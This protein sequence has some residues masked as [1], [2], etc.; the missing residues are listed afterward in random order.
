MKKKIITLFG[1]FC[2]SLNAFSYEFE[3]DAYKISGSVI[4]SKISAD[5]AEVNGNVLKTFYKNV[6][7]QKVLNGY[8]GPDF[9]S[10]DAL[11]DFFARLAYMEV[12]KDIRKDGVFSAGESWPTAWTRD[13]SYAIDLSLSFLFP[14]ASKKSLLSRVENN[15]ILQD[16]GSGGSYPVSTDRIVWLL[17]SYD[18]SLIEQNEEFSQMIYEVG[19]KTLDQD[20]NV[21]FDK[22]TGLFR[23]ESSFLDWRE[24]TYPR[25]ATNEYIANSF[26]LGT[27]ILY[28]K[29]LEIMQ[30]LSKKAEPSLTDFYRN[31]KD[32]LKLKIQ[33][34][35]W[36]SEK[37]YFASLILNDIELY[38]YEGYETLGE[39]LA[40]LFDL[41]P[42]NKNSTLLQAVTPQFWGLSVV[43]PQ[44]SSVPAYHND[45]VWPFVQGYRSLAAKKA[46]NGFV[47]EKEFSAMLYAASMF[48]TFKENYV[49]SVFSADTQINSNRQLWSDAG[50]LSVI[51]KIICG[52]DFTH[53]GLKICPMIPDTLNQGIR[54]RN[55]KLGYSTLN[56]EIRGT[57]DKVKSLEVNGNKETEYFVIPY[58]YLNNTRNI[59]VKV[60]MAK[61]DEFTDSYNKKYQ[62]EPVFSASAVMPPIPLTSVYYD[63]GKAFVQWKPKPKSSYKIVNAGKESFISE[64]EIPSR[65]GENISLYQVF[66]LSE[67]ENVPVMPGKLIRVENSKNTFFYEAEKAEVSGGEFKEETGFDVI[68]AKVSEDL[69]KA[70]VNC[71]AFIDKWGENEKDLIV[72]TVK[73]KKEGDYAVDFRY[74]N[75]HG[76]VNTGER[77]AVKTLSV[78]EKLFDRITFPQTG[79]WAS[80]AYTAPQVVHLTKGMHKILLSN[81]EYTKSQHGVYPYISLDLMR[82]SKIR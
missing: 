20:F 77:C 2:V 43:S 3:N 23:G 81:D 67:N 66:N 64:K 17:A 25:W 35:F 41:V 63:G 30:Q 22:K 56:L 4:Q 38:R 7:S 33:E 76:P 58:E 28:Y 55:L 1:L 57:G 60:V 34:N 75:G 13:M 70:D 48:Q 54:L 19:K 10:G 40:V 52:L 71:G 32:E 46:R 18:Y 51:Y 47:F 65:A 15:L 42:E 14:E 31:K 12:L 29:A 16:T 6:E 69:T 50:F 5:R 9:S 8:T 80:W 78:D 49:A 26:A 74:K 53:E 59:S 73:I 11:T 44:L 36:I 37:D 27:N 39:S 21:V 62:T 61:S 24:Q 45:A 79:A 72:F 68:N 82:I